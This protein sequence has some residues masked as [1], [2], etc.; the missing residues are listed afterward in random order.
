MIKTN[1]V[2]MN[3]R[4]KKFLMSNQIS[5]T[6]ILQ[7][8]CVGRMVKPAWHVGTPETNPNCAY[9]TIVRCIGNSLRCSL[10][11]VRWARDHNSYSAEYAQEDLL[12]LDVEGHDGTLYV[13]DDLDQ[14]ESESL[15]K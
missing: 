6:D 12:Y 9:G 1:W 7:R 2:I 13:F 14:E 10:I 5:A 8:N 11:T 4:S 15:S 3:K